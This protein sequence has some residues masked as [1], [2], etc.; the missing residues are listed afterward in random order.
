MGVKT[1]TLQALLTLPQQRLHYSPRLLPIP[2]THKLNGSSLGR[3]DVDLMFAKWAFNIVRGPGAPPRA[4]RAPP[5]AR[6]EVGCTASYLGRV[7]HTH[8]PRRK[9]YLLKLAP[10][11]LEVAFKL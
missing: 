5:R 3:P 6:G 8:P 7:S 1:V 4:R 11:L 10:R 9:P 2:P